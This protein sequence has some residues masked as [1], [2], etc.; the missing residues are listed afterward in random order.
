MCADESATAASTHGLEGVGAEE[1]E[2]VILGTG[3]SSPSKYRN[4]TSLYCDFFAKG[5]LL[6]DCGEG[7]LGQ[8]R[9]RYGYAGTE[10]R[11]RSL[12]AIWISHIHADHH[13]GLPGVLAE[14]ARILGPGAAPIPLFGP[15]PLRAVT[16]ACDRMHPLGYTWF[17]Q[18][19][20]CPKAQGAGRHL[21]GHWD[22]ASKLPDAAPTVARICKVR[23][24]SKAFPS[25]PVF[26]LASE[27]TG[28]Y[29]SVA[30]ICK[31]SACSCV[32]SRLHL[33]ALVGMRVSRASAR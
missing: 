21:D 33:N 19:Q 28:G 9:R 3:A 15:F 27:C 13:V 5:G 8:L 14:R 6:L 20:I 32:L 1:F 10:A 29:E 16:S 17:D 18:Y 26:C 24:L 12:R 31:V 22:R 23:A 4:V 25:F 2:C 30:R 7:T 11:L